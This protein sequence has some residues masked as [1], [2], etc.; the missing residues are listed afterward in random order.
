MHN[1]RTAATIIGAGEIGRALGR[2][3]V[4]NGARVRFWDKDPRKISF[5]GSL[6]DALEKSVV[7]F[8][9]VPSWG[10]YGAVRTI[11][12]FIHKNT[13]VVSLT[14]GMEPRTGQCV[15]DFLRQSLPARPPVVFLGGPMLA[16]ELDRHAPGV[17]IL[18]SEAENASRRVRALFGVSPIFFA[19]SSDPKSV[20][21]AGVLKN[22]YAL[23][24]G[25]ADGLGWDGNLKGYLAAQALREMEE[26]F[27]ALH[28]DPGVLEGIAGTADF[29]ATGFSCYSRNHE[30]GK[31]IA[32]GRKRRAPSE[33]LAALP[34]VVRMIPKKQFPLLAALDNIVR[35]RRDARV[36]FSMFLKKSFR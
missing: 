7:V 35:K 12:P 34:Y 33:G 36:T 30:T 13:I 19:Y 31:L 16:E 25:I 22:V 29:I 20:A 24:L 9:C 6:A 27:R 15:S 32:M 10:I 3:L 8:L 28:R 26:L 17:A 21:L 11:A 14:K 1:P 2:L 18:A 23:T 4:K 5:R